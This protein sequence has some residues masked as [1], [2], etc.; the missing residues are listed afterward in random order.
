MAC[1]SGRSSAASTVSV[2]YALT[3]PTA[4]FILSS[5]MPR[6]SASAIHSFASASA[7]VWAGRFGGASAAWSYPFTYELHCRVDQ[8]IL[9]IGQICLDPD[10]IFRRLPPRCVRTHLSNERCVLTGGRFLHAWSV[11][12]VRCL[13]YA[14]KSSGGF[15]ARR[16]LM[17]MN[18]FANRSSPSAATGEFRSSARIIPQAARV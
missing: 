13:A 9:L 1:E 18:W 16:N 10:I 5:R 3:S 11:V 2:R 7:A 6:R 8:D 12:T 14:T 17:A 15:F 4:S